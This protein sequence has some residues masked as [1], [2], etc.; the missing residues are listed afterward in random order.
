[1][2]DP[3]TA[4]ILLLVTLTLSLIVTR[5]GATAL[6][7]TG[8]SPEMARFQARSAFS[9]VGYTTSEAEA[10]VN[11]PVRRRIVMILMLLGNIQIAATMATTTLTAIG[12]TEN[13]GGA[14][15]VGLLVIGLIL[16]W[17]I[18]TSEWVAHR[19]SQTI[20]WA[21]QHF[22]EL[23]VQD[24]V[25]VLQL[26]NGFAVSEMT[27]DAGDWIA[28]QSLRELRLPD[29]GVMVLGIERPELGYIGAP[30]ADTRILPGDVL[31]VYSQTKRMEDLDAR[32]RDAQGMK[33]H[34]EACEEHTEFVEELKQSLTLAGVETG[35]DQSE[36]FRTEV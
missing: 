36:D 25:A 9:G 35:D 18:A 13:T 26:E 2:N 12:I 1:M 21:L 15:S 4:A 5:I 16:L 24:Y 23:E 33:A 29:E 28:D 11:H 31:I 32:R 17:V 22:S 30:T 27:V 34:Q 19:L 7:L 6:V 14:T 3:T 8:I 10:I 20:T